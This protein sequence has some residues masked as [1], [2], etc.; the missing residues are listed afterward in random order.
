MV[1]GLAG[2]GRL[3]LVP[4]VPS[5]AVTGVTPDP[6]PDPV[7][8]AA[9]QL[10]DLIPGTRPGAGGLPLDEIRKDFR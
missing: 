5:L 9:R 7:L 6:L 2:A 8:A 4:E 1:R 3:V 10:C